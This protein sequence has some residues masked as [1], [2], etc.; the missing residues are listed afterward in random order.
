[1]KTKKIPQ[2]MCV[3]CREMKPK[4]ELLRIVRTETGEFEIDETGKKNGR[5]AYICGS[6][7]CLARCIK[8]K[9]LNRAFQCNVPEQL[10]ISLTERNGNQ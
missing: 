9:A 6:G 1:M 10:Y 4:R 5:G 2:R 3:A 7:E 8:T